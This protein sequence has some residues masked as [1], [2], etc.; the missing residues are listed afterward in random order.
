[1]RQLLI[2]VPRG[3]GSTVL[4]IA[5]S[6]QG[7]HLIQ[8]EATGIDQLLD[9]VLVYVSNRSVEDFLGK[10]ETLPDANISLIP[11]GVIALQPPPDEAP[12][13]VT[14]VEER[15]PIEVFL[16]GLQ[17]VG[18]WKGFLGYA[19]V[20]GI[21]VWIGLYTN[22]I[23]LL[24]A[25]MLIAPFAGPA[26]NAALATA[27][28][29]L[30][31]LRRS[32]FR[33]VSALLVTITITFILSLAVQQ[34]TVTEQ[35][36]AASTVSAMAVLLPLTA[37]AAGALNLVQ[38]DRSSLVSGAATGVL[39]AAS[40]APPAGLIGM[41]IALGRW[42]LVINGV[43]VLL[44]QLI[45]INLSGALIF[46]LFGLS[47]HG[48][49]YNRGKTWALPLILTLTIISLIA[50][51]TWQ[52]SSRPNL[53]R[54]SITQRANTDIQ[55]VVQNSG[56]AKIVEANI[57]FTRPDIP[58]QNTLLATIYVQK[59]LEIAESNEAISTR[60]TQM[61]Q[62]QLLQKNYNVTPLIEVNVLEKP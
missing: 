40:L 61:I 47:A 56:L 38:S 19:A 30:T 35:M 3:S 34:Q 16:A 23:Y 26:M 9:V 13:Q 7:T 24:T 55:T 12:Q 58:E 15:S 57:R 32:V 25:A 49:R 27:R 45:G 53:Q 41:A 18:S 31:L 28:G 1:M 5:Q 37:G 8:F 48:A 36:S 50:L 62:N 29:D 42:K 2:Q 44:L 22:T 60:L 52:F 33:Y 17:S 59:N 11:R 20:A 46:R 54:A 21:V 10:L 39:V 6:C 4:D 43:F 51:L 14:Q